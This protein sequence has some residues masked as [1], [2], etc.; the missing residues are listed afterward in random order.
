MA[1][2]NNPID[3]VPML[4]AEGHFPED[5][6]ALPNL[7]SSAPAPD[8]SSV[9]RRSLMYSVGQLPNA[10][11]DGNQSL[12]DTWASIRKNT[13]AAISL[14]EEA[15]LQKQATYQFKKDRA[16]AFVDLSISNDVSD[17]V[18]YGS[19]IALGLILRENAAEIEKGA[20]E[21]KY[22][23]GLQAVL[24]SGDYAEAKKMQTLWADHDAFESSVKRQSR[25]AYMQGLIE[26]NIAGQEN[27]FWLLNVTDLL[28]YFV[29]PILSG[30]SQSGNVTTPG[31]G[32]ENF[33]DNILSG[34][35]LNKE[36]E[37]LSSMS[38]YDFYNGGAEEFIK[39]VGAN[40]TFL[41]GTNNMVRNTLFDMYTRRTPS[42]DEINA[43]GALDAALAPFLIWDI[44]NGGKIIRSIPTTLK[45]AGLKS[46]NTSLIKS[47][48][49]D[50]HQFG[51]AKAAE[52]YGMAS[53]DVEKALKFSAMDPEASPH[54]LSSAGVIIT[55]IDKAEEAAKRLL[56]NPLLTERLTEEEVAAALPLYEARVKKDFGR[57]VHDIRLETIPLVNGSSVRSPVVRLGTTKDGLFIDK[58]RAEEAVANIGLADAKVVDIVDDNGT[59]YAVEG[60]LPITESQ[61]YVAHAPGSTRPKNFIE[62][63]LY[64][65]RQTSADSSYGLAETVVAKRQRVVTAIMKSIGPYFDKLNISE[66]RMLSDILVRAEQDQKWYDHMEFSVLWARLSGHADEI[67]EIRDTSISVGNIPSPGGVQPDAGFLAEKA[68]LEHLDQLKD[69]SI[70]IG[71]QIDD[72]VRDSGESSEADFWANKADDAANALN[73]E[74]SRLAKEIVNLGKQTT[75]RPQPVIDAFLE[76]HTYKAQRASNPTAF[77]PEHESLWQALDKAADDALATQEKAGDTAKAR[78]RKSAEMTMAKE[79]REATPELD[80]LMG[81]FRHPDGVQFSEIAR[82]Y[83]GSRLVTPRLFSGVDRKALMRLA[84]SVQPVDPK[85]RTRVTGIRILELPGGRYIAWAG[86]EDFH[87]NALNQL[88]MMLADRGKPLIEKSQ[89]NNIF[90]NI[91]PSKTGAR[92]FGVVETAEPALLEGGYTW[93]HSS[94]STFNDFTRKIDS[95]SV[96]G[97]AFNNRVKDAES[98]ANMSLDQAMT[99]GPA[100]EQFREAVDN[101]LTLAETNKIIN[102][103]GAVLHT[104]RQKVMSRPVEYDPSMDGRVSDK[105]RSAFNKMIEMN[106]IVHLLRNEEAYLQK[107]VRGIQTFSFNSAA[108]ALDVLDV[109]GVIYRAGSIPP[110]P[111]SRVYNLSE[112]LHYVAKTD[113]AVKAG[114]APRLTDADI[115]R[116]IKK[117]G[118]VMV[119]LEQPQAMRGNITVQWFIGKANDFEV[120]PL[121]FEQIGYKAGGPR[122]YVDKYFGKQA[123]VGMQGDTKEKYLMNP[124]TY[125][126]GTKAQVEEW[127]LVMNDAGAI[128]NNVEDPERRAELLAELLDHRQGYPSGSELESMIARKEFDP[129]YPVEAVYDREMPSDHAKIKGGGWEDMSEAEESG[130]NSYFQTQGRMY[131]SPKGERLRDWQGQDATIIDPFEAMNKSLGQIAGLSSLSDYKLREVEKWVK[132]FGQYLDTTNLSRDASPMRVFQESVFRKDMPG[133]QAI[134]NSAEA[135]RDT[136][137]RVL[138]WRSDTDREF[139]YMSRQLVDFVSGGKA[140]KW[141]KAVNRGVNWTLEKDP[142]AKAR[143]LAHHMKMGLGNVAQFPMQITTM[144][145]ATSIDAVGGM[146]GMFNLVPMVGYLAKTSGEEWLEHWVKLGWHK[147]IGFEDPEE[148]KTMMRAAKQSGRFDIGGSHQLINYDGVEAAQGLIGKTGKTLAKGS[149]FFNEAERWNQTIG[150]TIAWHRAKKMGLTVGTPKFNE[151]LMKTSG[152]FTFN[153]NKAGAAAWQQ[154][155]TSI[156]TQF[157]S[158]Q[159]RVL[160]ALLGKQFTAVEKLR[161]LLGQGILYGTAGIPLASYISEQ[162]RGQSGEVAEL[163]TWEGLVDRGII[164]TML[165]VMGTDMQFGER[166]AVGSF[167][168]DTFR[169]LMGMSKYGQV[170]FVD[171]MG[172]PLYGI[173]KSIFFGE[174]GKPGTFWEVTRFMS[175]ESGGDTGL[176]L[177]SNALIN[178]AKNVSSFNNAY[179][180][181]MVW[182]YGQYITTS[183]KIALDELP[184]TDAFG[185]FLGLQPGEYRE[186]VAKQ[187]WRRNRQEIVKSIS[188]EIMELRQRKSREPDAG[189]EI[190]S[191]ME[192]FRHL[193]TED[194]WIDALTM[195]NR[196]PAN[197]AIMDGLARRYEIEKQQER[198]ALEARK[199]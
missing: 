11:P 92:R 103:D 194:L 147:N 152:D 169:E 33:F 3:A 107:A 128:I 65:S 77:P 179:K 97:P 157:L 53:E 90:I 121:K 63:F 116:M 52:N 20:A 95:Y 185:V 197:E 66:R 155:W 109:D 119:R 195:A 50:A 7:V 112:D 101:G 46:A 48:L 188:G 105:A 198:M 148:W 174:T 126:V 111:S 74:R 44:V 84:D 129:E 171:V 125:I 173:G 70:S 29:N 22:V 12:I 117:E 163:G 149:F 42:A 192:V 31:I 24:A 127:A 134:K 54:D 110:V 122:N 1:K 177:T 189:E 91:D 47:V 156:P 49:A 75:N 181:Y 138:G 106:N 142:V 167:V 30:M 172:G 39:G 118:Y 153:M 27:R 19:N 124:N 123:R 141:N 9:L 62:R 15:Q 151:F 164:D 67:K 180:A 4:G 51:I 59:L 150:W 80:Y 79:A 170:S 165:G 40:A 168:T 57:H 159:A 36:S 60:R 69:Q 193:H 178:L 96:T 99:G 176:P 61:F 78:M 130:L 190:D 93:V 132:T 25:K 5:T 115:H 131:S 28:G 139:E 140:N 113:S 41:G 43:F 13:A 38:D 68:A 71:K 182:N 199:K 56:G 16:Q 183:G 144:L 89:V 72:L 120:K 8:D 37:A 136:I 6:A 158:Y 196:S 133:A 87:E 86:H 166:A 58:A 102:A 94:T 104:N 135:Q 88:N 154:G 187:D 191:Q 100:T 10:S 14:G 143:M 2:P 81:L 55:D 82:R 160:E 76:P 34:D 184:S 137:K 18:R 162:M 85:W 45:S 161:L 17:D 32:K 26:D 73:D 175:A 108:G 83:D 145:A 21:K 23:E 146:R 35:R 114:V 64:G 186:Y 98:K